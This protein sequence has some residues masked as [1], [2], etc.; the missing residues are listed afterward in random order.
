MVLREHLPCLSSRLMPRLLFGEY[1]HGNACRL[2]CR[3]FEIM[4]QKRL[5][6]CHLSGFRQFPPTPPPIRNTS[7]QWATQ[8][9]Y[10][11]HIFGTFFCFV[12]FSSSFFFLQQVLINL[13]QLQPNLDSSPAPLSPSLLPTRYCSPSLSVMSGTH[14]KLMLR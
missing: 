12:F 10:Q 1:T 7:A 13:P 3:L 6:A 11:P 14:K 4:T 9:K 8:H 5:S 2:I